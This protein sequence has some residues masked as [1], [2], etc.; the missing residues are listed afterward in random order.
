MF[1][2]SNR[3]ALVT[4]A[5]QGVGTEIAKALAGQ[6]AT[7]IVN[8]Y[9]Q[10]RAESAAN[11]ILSA[12]GR[13]VPMQADVTDLTVFYEMA[14]K[15]RA[16]VG[17][18]DIL[19]N[20]AGNA[21]AGEFVPTQFRDLAVEDWDRFIKINLYAVLNGARVVLD[22]MCNRGWGRIITI[23]SGAWRAGNG[24]G[25]SLYAAGKG[26]AIGFTKQL[27]SEV[28]QF[29]VTV[30]CVELGMINNVP[31]ADQW[32]KHVPMRRPGTP[33]DIAAV[34]IYLASEEASWITGQVLPVN[35]GSI[36]A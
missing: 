26:G 35:G 10:D 23:S 31:M 20:N 6:G 22:D 21:G 13:A 32:A 34:V 1:D 3:V 24:M 30:N 25:I 15:V 27:S 28:G 7:V 18:I 17:P 33:W 36:T 4:G 14:D 29:G 5:G 2:L 11:E 12:G 16:S 19:V 9:H 8:D